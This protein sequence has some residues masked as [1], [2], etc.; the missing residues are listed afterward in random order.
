MENIV[1]LITGAS[2]GI[3]SAIAKKIS[4][5]IEKGIIILHYNSNKKSVLDLKKTLETK[6]VKIDIVKANLEKKRRLRIIM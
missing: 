6:N 3:G 5:S 1:Y 2:G 4:N